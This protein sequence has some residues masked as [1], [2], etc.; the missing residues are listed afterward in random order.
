MWTSSGHRQHTANGASHGKKHRDSHPWTRLGALLQHFAAR[1]CC[2][3]LKWQSLVS[4]FS[5]GLK[6]FTL[7]LSYVPSYRMKYWDRLR[8]ST[9]IIS[10]LLI[11]L[12]WRKLQD[13]CDQ[14]DVLSYVEA[15]ISSL[16]LHTVFHPEPLGSVVGD[17]IIVM[18]K[19][20]HED[21]S[22]VAEELPEYCIPPFC[23]PRSM[24]SAKLAGTM[25]LLLT[26][27]LAG[28]VQYTSSIPLRILPPALSK[29][30]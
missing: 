13:F 9:S 4:T 6:A 29:P 8:V 24:A 26:E 17:K 18:A 12:L 15:S 2:S 10:T 11:V 21:T 19:M 30:L 14:Y 7:F 1:F 5:H 25:L 3:W 22:W 28:N 20:E 16:A 27:F 23:L